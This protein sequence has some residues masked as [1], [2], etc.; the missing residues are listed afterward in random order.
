MK[1]KFKQQAY[2]TNAVEAVAACFAGQPYRAAIAYQSDSPAVQATW[3]DS[4]FANSP[5]VLDCAQLPNNINRVQRERQL[6][7]SAA[8]STDSISTVNLTVEMETGTGKT[9]C[10]IKTLFE[11]NRL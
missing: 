5:L 10:Y 9:Y 7:V 3:V 4:G 1:L 2:Q 6:P 8:L 11:L